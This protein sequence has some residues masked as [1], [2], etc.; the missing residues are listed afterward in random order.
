MSLGHLSEVNL[1]EPK[2]G[3]GMTSLLWWRQG[4]I[5]LIEEYCRKDVEMTRR[6]FV[7]GHERGYLLYRDR[8]GRMV[9]VPV[10]W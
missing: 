7:L 6:L 3:N 8:V 4:R 5:D 9:R 2:T 10:K 1:N